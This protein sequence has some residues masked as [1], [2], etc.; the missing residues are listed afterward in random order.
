LAVGDWLKDNG[1]EAHSLE[2]AVVSQTE[3][4]GRGS[5]RMNADKD[6]RH[7]KTYVLFVLICVYPR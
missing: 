3:I 7:I 4:I 1:R 2:F 5:T 6:S